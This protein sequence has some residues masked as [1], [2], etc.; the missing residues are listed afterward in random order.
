MLVGLGLAATVIVCDVQAMNR[1]IAELERIINE[2]VGK[3]LMDWESRGGGTFG[4]YWRRAVPGIRS[5][6]R[7][8]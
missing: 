4:R 5:L 8:N 1:R 2:M 6:F 7:E 3:P